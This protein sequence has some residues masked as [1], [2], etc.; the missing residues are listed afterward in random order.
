MKFILFLVPCLVL[1]TAEEPDWFGKFE[2][3]MSEY[4]K[5][6]KNMVRSDILNEDGTAFDSSI[7]VLLAIAEPHICPV[8]AETCVPDE[9][10]LIGCNCRKGFQVLGE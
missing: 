3:Q 1:S 5:W 7:A 2:Q 10:L 9:N 8:E 4:V 6:L